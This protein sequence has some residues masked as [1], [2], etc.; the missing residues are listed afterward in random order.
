MQIDLSLEKF[1]ELPEKIINT[2][3]QN[4]DYLDLLSDSTCNMFYY[5]ELKKDLSLIFDKFN[6]T[7]FL[8]T[9]SKELNTKT[10]SSYG[11]RLGSFS[12]NI[13][14][15]IGNL[16]GKSIDNEIWASSIYNNIVSLS[17]KLTYKEAIYL[18][19]TFLSNKTEEQI[20]EKLSICR[21]SLQKIKK[22]CLVKIYMELKT[23]ENVHLN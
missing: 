4:P 11:L 1:L 6:D 5:K 21:K 14:D 20:S 15:E 3:L 22:S 7:K 17:H 2:S 23:N 13:V 19:E 10:T 18:V 9:Y 12:N 16:V 8:Y